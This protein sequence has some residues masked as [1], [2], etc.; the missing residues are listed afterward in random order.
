MYEGAGILAGRPF[1]SQVYVSLESQLGSYAHGCDKTYRPAD[2]VGHVP[3][4]QRAMP[5]LVSTSW[6]TWIMPASSLFISTTRAVS[7][8]KSEFLVPTLMC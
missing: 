4:L 1:S 2:M 6:M 3:S 7:F 8:D 5:V